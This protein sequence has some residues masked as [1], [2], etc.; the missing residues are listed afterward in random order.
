MEKHFPTFATNS[1]AFEPCDNSQ[2]TTAAICFRW[3]GAQ[4]ARKHV[5]VWQHFWPCLSYLQEIELQIFRKLILPE[6]IKGFEPDTAEET[7]A[8][9]FHRVYPA[10]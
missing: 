9:I 10:K 8:M 3:F 1:P 5:N 4:E 2:S 6:A 7:L